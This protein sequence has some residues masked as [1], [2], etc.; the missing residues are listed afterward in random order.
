MDWWD[1]DKHCSKCGKLLAPDD[2]KYINDTL[3]CA[4]CYNSVYDFLNASTQKQSSETTPQYTL[5]KYDKNQCAI[6]GSKIGLRYGVLKDDVKICPHCCT[7]ANVKCTDYLFDYTIN[8]ILVKS[9]YSFKQ[10]SNSENKVYGSDSTPQYKLPQYD[11]NQCAICGTKLGWRYGLLKNDDKICPDCCT[12][13]N[14]RCSDTLFD[15]TVN[16]IL[17]MSNYSF[18]QANVSDNKVYGSLIDPNHL[19]NRSFTNTQKPKQKTNSW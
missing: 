13:A 12:N 16:D 19:V 5:S 10:D 2:E 14:V 9:N 3:V 6:C 15:Y 11:K 8:D 17:A 18:I 4:N 1:M 7:N